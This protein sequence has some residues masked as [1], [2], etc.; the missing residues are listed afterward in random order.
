M[1]PRRRQ[2]SAREYKSE[3]SGRTRRR[4]DFHGLRETRTRVMFHCT[5]QK[6]DENNT[7]KRKKRKNAKDDKIDEE[8]NK[9]VNRKYYKNTRKNYENL[10]KPSKKWENVQVIVARHSPLAFQNISRRRA[11]FNLCILRRKARADLARRHPTPEI[12]LALA[13]AG[14]AG[15]GPEPGGMCRK[16]QSWLA[17]PMP[18][19]SMSM[20]CSDSFS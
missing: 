14:C 8:R 1:G 9:R 17:S 20:S 15:F 6:T 10:R 18:T 13:L 5:R 3:A 7:K 2:S 12:Y 19:T 16:S 11:P 4:T